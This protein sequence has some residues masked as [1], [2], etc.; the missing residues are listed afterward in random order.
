MDLTLDACSYDLKVSPNFDTFT[1]D[2][3]VS[4]ELTVNK[5]SLTGDLA[6]QITLHSKELCFV[7]ASFKAPGKDAVS[8]EEIRVNLKATTVTFCF[9]EEIPSDAETLILSIQFSGFL[10]NQMAGFYRSKVCFE[11]V[12][13]GWCDTCLLI[14]LLLR[15]SMPVYGH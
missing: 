7:T 2:G 13:K 5:D 3:D 8:A 12:S 6:K 10:N 1:F 15:H 4:I 11:A 14:F 9:P